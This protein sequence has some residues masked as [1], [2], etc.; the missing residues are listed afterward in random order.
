[1]DLYNQ[2]FNNWTALEPIKKDKKIYWKC[3]CKCG[4]EKEIEQYAL[5]SGHSKSCGCLR[6]NLNAS[7]LLN[8]QFGALIA[9]EKTDK[10][11]HGRVIWKCQ[12]VCGKIVEF[13]SQRLRQTKYP[14]CGCQSSLIGQTFGKLTVI[15]KAPNPTKSRNLY[16]KC[17]CECGNTSVCSTGDLRSGKVIGCGCSKSIGQYNIAKI[18]SNN[19]IKFKTEYSFPDLKDKKLLRFDFAVFDL[20]NNLIRLIEFDGVQHT[21]KNS[22]WYSEKVVEH[23]LMKN[24]Y[25]KQNNIPLVR[26]PY[27]KR[28]TLTLTDIMGESYLI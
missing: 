10:R 17:K 22:P 25:A 19:S 8:Q 4:T 7:N 24:N 3:R 11:T 15:D 21:D 12:C 1:M 6:A 28:D 14:H 20:K 13:D 23:D 26:I 27:S 2:T 9:I 5:T 16:W 18:L